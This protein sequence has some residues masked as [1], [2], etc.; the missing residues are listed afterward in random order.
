MEKT[1]QSSTELINV[2]II[3]H[4]PI[5]RAGLRDMLERIPDINIQLETAEPSQA[6]ELICQLHPHIILL[7]LDPDAN[8]DRA[9]TDEFRFNDNGPKLIALAE[10]TQA[11]QILNVLGIRVSAFALKTIDADSLVNLIRR[12]ACGE[13]LPSL[14]PRESQVLRCAA[15]GESNKRI[16]R[17]LN[18]REKTVK[19]HLTSVFRKLGVA[20]RTQAVMHAFDNG[21]LLLDAN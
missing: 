21:W 19:N 15:G 6:A 3:E 14:S 13:H 7:G 4:S 8:A 1:M 17:S 10:R 5:Y 16:A 2:M 9:L 12:C 20:N 18:I 11:Q